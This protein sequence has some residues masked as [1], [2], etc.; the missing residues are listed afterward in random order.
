[1]EQWEESNENL[2]RG[3]ATRTFDYRDFKGY[4][5]SRGDDEMPTSMNVL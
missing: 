1:M 3:A 2:T 4:F 5:A